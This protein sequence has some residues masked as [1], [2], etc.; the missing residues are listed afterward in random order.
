MVAGDWCGEAC[1]AGEGGMNGVKVW[2]AGAAF[3]LVVGLVAGTFAE[4]RLWF[5]R[6]LRAHGDVE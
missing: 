1:R 5:Y 6:Y 3:G 2:C 4:D